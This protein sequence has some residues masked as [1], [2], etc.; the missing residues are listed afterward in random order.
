M[1]RKNELAHPK[2]TRSPS[3]FDEWWHMF[4]KLTITLL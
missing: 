1:R 4:A 2:R 3:P